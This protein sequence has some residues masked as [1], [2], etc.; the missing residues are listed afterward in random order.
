MS[1]LSLG[2]TIFDED[3]NTIHVLVHSDKDN[4]GF[5]KIDQQHTGLVTYIK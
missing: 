4:G 5:G 2:L 3:F 1:L